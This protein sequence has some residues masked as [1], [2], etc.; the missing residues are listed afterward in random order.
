MQN[1]SVVILQESEEAILKLVALIDTNENGYSVVGTACDGDTGLKLIVEKKPDFVITEIVLAGI[2]GFGII[3]RINEYGLDTKVIVLSVVSRDEIINRAMK[4]GASYYMVKPVKPN[5]IIERL[6]DMSENSINCNEKIY[7]DYKKNTLDEKISNIFINV[8]IP[9]HIKG[10]CYL[11]EGVKMA[12]DN[13]DVINNIT[14]KL[15]PMIGKKYETS[16]S[17]VERAIR[18]AI[19]VAWDRGDPD[20]LNSIF[21]YTVANSKGKPTNSEFIAMIADKLRLRIKNAS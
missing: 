10:Y 1:R 14:K 6:K 16:A 21:G 7:V 11:R 12:V 5:V 17:K 3:D 2:D 9:P 19:E 18:H 13:P 20:V 8:G 4:K 15:Y